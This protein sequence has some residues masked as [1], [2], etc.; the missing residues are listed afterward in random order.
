[1]TQNKKA[2]TDLPSLKLGEGD[3][4]PRKAGGR[5]TVKKV[6]ERIL[7]KYLHEEHSPANTLT[8]NDPILGFW[9]PKE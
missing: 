3:H 1:M 4:K 8:S 9:P 2:W 7:Y 6:R 5:Y